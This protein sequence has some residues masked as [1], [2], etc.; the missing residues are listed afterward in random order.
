MSIR[1]FTPAE[2]DEILRLLPP[3]RAPLATVSQY[4]TK[5]RN[6]V[7]RVQLEDIELDPRGLPEFIQRMVEDHYRAEAE[8]GNV[9]LVVASAIC[10]L[11]SQMA[12]SSFHSA[13]SAKSLS[14]SV[15][16][17]ISL[18]EARSSRL[19]PEMTI[20]FTD[21]HLTKQEALERGRR[22]VGVTV[23]DCILSYDIDS[24][25]S[26]PLQEWHMWCQ[27]LR[28]KTIPTTNWVMRLT[29]NRPFMYKHG[30]TMSDLVAVIEAQSNG[31]ICM[32]S[33]MSLGLI[34]I[35]PVEEALGSALERI[36][37]RSI[38]DPDQAGLYFL[39]IALLSYFRK[40]YV[41]GNPKISA[42]F[43]STHSALSIVLDEKKTY[44]EERLAKA[45]PED[46]PR[47]ER[48][49]TIRLN[50]FKIAETGIDNE[51]LGELAEAAGLTLRRM[52]P[53]QDYI[54]VISDTSPIAV[55][56][57]Q[58]TAD[59]EAALRYKKEHL[60]DDSLWTPTRLQRANEVVFI[61]T[62]GTDLL[63][64]LS[65]PDV[66]Y[67][68]TISNDFHEMTKVFGI[69]SARNNMVRE[70]YTLLTSGGDS[71]DPSLVGTVL[72]VQTNWGIVMKISQNNISRSVTGP[73]AAATDQR[74]MD[75]LLDA[76]M[77][78]KKESLG[79]TTSIITGMSMPHGTGSVKLSVD[80]TVNTEER[81]AAIRAKLQ[82]Q[83]NITVPQVMAGVPAEPA[84]APKKI[85]DV[86]AGLAALTA[87]R[88]SET[89]Q[90]KPPDPAPAAKPPQPIAPPVN[91]NASTAKALAVLRRL[92]PVL[93]RPPTA[94]S[95]PAP[96]SSGI[97]TEKAEI[98]AE[99]TE[100]EATKPR[101]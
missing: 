94:P 90:I 83:R 33:P 72:N 23:Y 71:L 69:E 51:R 58:L 98:A 59:N 12:M 31:P 21:K 15:R 68:Y 101:T 44:N 52:E 87:S 93:L 42:V 18:L 76:A 74:A 25:D 56:R 47:M 54:Q 40:A 65:E 55:I 80:K 100:I 39:Y 14:T 92:P 43:P 78:A 45:K 49:W 50:K 26:Y 35:Y 63:E 99:K 6:E 73:I 27:R 16:E 85:V 11:L 19:N 37:G 13:G 7:I 70:L 82:A 5:S 61:Q 62:E 48:T 96:V 32:F 28:N 3:V 17:V 53:G 9:I 86:A 67:R 20:Y 38:I 30:L 57:S 41:K 22:L 46:R 36:S 4:N 66:D 34:D 81:L 79:T 75:I 88:P 24:R 95:C 64:T 91:L 97:H 29:L 84:V 8:T 2:I 77:I 89:S 10:A 60:A 1:K